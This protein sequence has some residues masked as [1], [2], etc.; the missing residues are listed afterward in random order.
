MKN[1]Y[2]SEVLSFET[3]LADLINLVKAFYKVKVAFSPR[4][5]CFNTDE[6]ISKIYIESELIPF[7]Y[8]DLKLNLSESNPSIHFFSSYSINLLKNSFEGFSTP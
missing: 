2:F 4:L 1:I 7:N 5:W 3:E 8:S 6:I